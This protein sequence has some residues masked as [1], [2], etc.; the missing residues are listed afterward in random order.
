MAKQHG[1]EFFGNWEGGT[2]VIDNLEAEIAL[3]VQQSLMRF[4]LKAERLAK[5]H[6]RD[7]DLD[8]AQLSPATL[9]ETVEWHFKENSPATIFLNNIRK[10]Y[11][12]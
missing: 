11:K 2:G 10:R 1:I 3:A 6:I 4:G 9:E 5:M 7:Q 8:W 12:V